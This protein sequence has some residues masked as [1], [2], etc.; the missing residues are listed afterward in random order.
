LHRRTFLRAHAV[1][2]E[3]F[4]GKTVALFGTSTTTRAKKMATFARIRTEASALP[5]LRRTVRLRELLTVLRTFAPAA[6]FATFIARW[7]YSFWRCKIVQV[8][9]FSALAC[10]YFLPINSLHVT[11]I[12]VVVHAHAPVEYI[13]DEIKCGKL[14]VV[15]NE[16]TSHLKFLT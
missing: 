1:I 10:D 15:A 9:V 11:E 3:I 7:T 4:T 5:A 16:M 8:K 12:V 14:D 2:E 13:Y 6:L